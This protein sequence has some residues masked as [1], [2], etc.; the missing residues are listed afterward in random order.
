M[1]LKV[2]KPPLNASRFKPFHMAI[3]EF[4][5]PF[6]TQMQTRALTIAPIFTPDQQKKRLI[7]NHLFVTAQK[8][9]T[10]VIHVDNFFVFASRINSKTCRNS[11]FES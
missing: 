8:S 3:C 2:V 11:S 5:C 1:D 4:F 9:F 10:I 7:A 6:I